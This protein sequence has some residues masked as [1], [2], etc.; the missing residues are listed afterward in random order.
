MDVVF[1]DAEWS[2]WKR[3]KDERRF[4]CIS[5]QLES[6]HISGWNF[7]QLYT[8][9]YLSD[10]AS[11]SL[12]GWTFP[13][14]RYSTKL[15]LFVL[16][17]IKELTIFEE[18]LHHWKA[19]FIYHSIENFTLNKTVYKHSKKNRKLI[20]KHFQNRQ[21]GAIYRLSWKLASPSSQLFDLDPEPYLQ[22][23]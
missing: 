6:K 9:E 22:H 15:P 1:P 21:C 17:M 14:F 10:P 23:P 3:I 18:N 8:L 5:A 7:Y 13:I 12:I 20:S 19:G 4:D 2:F 16:T 11:F